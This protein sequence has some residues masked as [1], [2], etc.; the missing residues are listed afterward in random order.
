MPP[1]CVHIHVCSPNAT[2]HPKHGWSPPPAPLSRLSQY[3]VGDP[4]S[5][6]CLPVLW[7]RARSFPFPLHWRE[8]RMAHVS[9]CAGRV[10]R[11]MQGAAYCARRLHHAVYPSRVC[12]AK[13]QRSS[14]RNSRF[15]LTFFRFIIITLFSHSNHNLFVT[16]IFLYHGFLYVPYF[17]FHEN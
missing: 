4:A 3:V 12:C 6:L 13:M 1:A 7:R 10:A 15:A 16:M 2:A 11:G 9:A 14:M 5:F 8:H 17:S